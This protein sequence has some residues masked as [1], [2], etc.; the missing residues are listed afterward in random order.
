MGKERA[1]GSG[2]VR[3]M[4]VWQ[5]IRPP[6]PFI[7]PVAARIATHNLAGLCAR[8]S[9]CRHAHLQR[10][11]RFRRWRA[12]GKAE[13]RV[14]SVYDDALCPSRNPGPDLHRSQR[15]C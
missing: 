13:N 9:L 12:M 1:A 8:E 6:T 3:T 2:Q 10:S 7:A 11:R 4:A 14:L 15:H 5:T